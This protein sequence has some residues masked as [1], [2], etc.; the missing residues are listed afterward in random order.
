MQALRDRLEASVRHFTCAPHE[1]DMY[2]DLE[3][4]DDW[5]VC[6]DAGPTLSSRTT[7]RF[8][9][10]SPEQDEDPMQDVVVYELP[11]ATQWWWQSLCQWFH[12]WWY[13]S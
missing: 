8:A 7:Y 4:T 2:A 10:Y 1:E 5:N 6:N 11:A 13:Q 12:L 3:D 9:L